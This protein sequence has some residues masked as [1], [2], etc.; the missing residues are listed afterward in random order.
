MFHCTDVKQEGETGSGRRE[1]KRKGCF[2][3]CPGSEFLGQGVAQMDAG[4]RPKTQNRR[5]SLSVSF[6]R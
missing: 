1:L 3:L 6:E 5:T 4:E 2:A